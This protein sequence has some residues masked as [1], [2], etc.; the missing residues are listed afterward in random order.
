M[1]FQ[2]PTKFDERRKFHRFDQ[3]DCKTLASLW[4]K[5]EVALVSALD[6]FITRQSEIFLHG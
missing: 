2:A 4:P 5:L 1:K 6:E 3:D